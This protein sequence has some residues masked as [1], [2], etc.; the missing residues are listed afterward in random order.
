MRSR[1]WEVL[2][3]RVFGSWELHQRALAFP[4]NAEASASF[5]CNGFGQVAWLINICAFVICCVVGK[6]LH[7][8]GIKKR[9]HYG[10][11]LR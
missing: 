1:V 4:Q 6:K 5:H 8:N 7:G 11:D 2:N 3:L 10:I 9:G